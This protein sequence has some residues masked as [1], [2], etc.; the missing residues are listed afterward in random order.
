MS[1][2]TR[3]IDLAFGN[4]NGS[5]VYTLTNDDPDTIFVS[6]VFPTEGREAFYVP[7]LI[8]WASL[9]I[10]FNR[11]GE[12]GAIADLIRIHG[13]RLANPDARCDYTGLPK[14]LSRGST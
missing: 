4:N 14:L 9:V 5:K 3:P 6:D 13:R 7:I 11:I 10:T 2:Q 12:Q 1:T 8:S